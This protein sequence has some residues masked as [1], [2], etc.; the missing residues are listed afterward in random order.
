LGLQTVLA[1]VVSYLVRGNKIVA[2]TLTAVSNP[3]TALPLYGLCYWVGQLALGRHTELPNLDS[4][5]SLDAFLALGPGFFLAMFI[6][7][8]VVG[9]VGSAA[10]YF[11]ANRI[12]AT[13]G[14]WHARHAVSRPVR[15]GGVHPEDS[16][17]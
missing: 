12:F 14:R 4:V 6:G 17:G 5:R 1:V 8:T 9:L 2:A 11:S 13:L 16:A 3:I 15:P 7:T 10:L